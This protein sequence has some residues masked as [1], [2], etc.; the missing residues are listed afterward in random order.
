MKR[1]LRTAAVLMVALV[2]LIAWTVMHRDNWYAQDFASRFIRHVDTLGGSTQSFQVVQGSIVVRALSSGN[3]L[4]CAQVR[5]R[6]AGQ[7][8]TGPTLMGTEFHPTLFGTTTRDVPSRAPAT[9]SDLFY[10]RAFC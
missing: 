1:V 3:R 9:P 4:V 8:A 5:V 7:D 10:L 6:Q 2:V